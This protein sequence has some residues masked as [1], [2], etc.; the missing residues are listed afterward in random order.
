MNESHTLGIFEAGISL[1]GEMQRLGEII[2]PEIGIFT[3]TGD[4]HS[5]GFTDLTQ[6]I[7]EKLQTMSEFHCI[8]LNRGLHR[9]R[10]ILSLL[11]GMT[12]PK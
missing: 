12:L 7:N 11:V 4:A 5:D 9:L 1:P 3:Y 10:G 2:D 6:K 8:C